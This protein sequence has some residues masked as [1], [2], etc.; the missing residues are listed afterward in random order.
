MNISPEQRRML[1]EQAP[2]S[3]KLVHGA[4]IQAMEEFLSR[5]NGAHD[6]FVHAYWITHEEHGDE[7][8]SYCR[9]CAQRRIGELE[10]ETLRSEDEEGW[11]LCGGYDVEHGPATCDICG[12]LLNYVIGDDHAVDELSHFRDNAGSRIAN[13][14]EILEIRALA[15]WALELGP[16][17]LEEVEEV[18]AIIGKID[19]EGY[20]ASLPVVLEEVEQQ[21]REAWNERTAKNGKERESETCSSQP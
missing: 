18:M 13:P 5:T 16:S 20:E 14:V 12:R 17:R 11:S 10:S 1:D 7:G 21:S 4:H 6:I 15:E 2:D 19:M 8:E 3:D 9:E